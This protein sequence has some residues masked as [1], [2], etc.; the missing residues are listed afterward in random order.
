MTGRMRR[1]AIAAMLAV[2]MS[3][4]GP[5]AAQQPA[6]GAALAAI[7]GQPDPNISMDTLTPNEQ[8]TF[9]SC[10][11]GQAVAAYKVNLPLRVDDVTTLTDVTADGLTVT[12]HMTARVAADTV[13]LSGLAAMRSSTRA[14]VCENEQL[15]AMIG[16]GGAYR[17]VWKD[18]SGA[19]IG[20]TTIDSC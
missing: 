13:S 14:V 1:Q 8:R 17:Y 7:C 11:Q 4:T 12:Y 6:D 20:E 10:L 5:A 16:I 9:V 19:V 2:A 15:I 18:E 3:S